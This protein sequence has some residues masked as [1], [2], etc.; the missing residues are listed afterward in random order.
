[1]TTYILSMVSV[2]M[3]NS[4]SKLRWMSY[5]GQ[6]GAAN[7]YREV[8]SFRSHLKTLDKRLPLAVKEHS[9][10]VHYNLEVQI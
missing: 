1:M 8:I 2:T 6:L 4:L 3:Y 5:M 7:S 10:F 9:N